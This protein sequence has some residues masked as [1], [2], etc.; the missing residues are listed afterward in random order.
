[1]TKLII[2]RARDWERFLVEA[3][4]WRR[5]ISDH[6]GHHVCAS[7]EFGRWAVVNIEFCKR[8]ANEQWGPIYELPSST[9]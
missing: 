2:K 1:M 6:G 5:L 3:N 8:L 9:R 4:A 7:K